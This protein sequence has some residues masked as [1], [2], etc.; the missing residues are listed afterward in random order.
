MEGQAIQ[1]RPQ[2][3]Q[4][5]IAVFDNYSEAQQAQKKLQEAEVSLRSIS[6]EGDINAYE[7]VAAMGTTV[8]KEAG[9]LLGAFF[10]GIVGVIFVSIVSTW[11]HG[12]VIN[13]TFNQT[14]VLALTVIG[15]FVG[16]I[17][18]N[19]YRSAKLPQQKQKGNPNVPRRYQIIAEGDSENLAKAGEILGYSAS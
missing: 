4:K 15:G 17:A 1:Q 7:E 2:M 8:G 9:I 10:G 14:S 12:E 6:I 5:E 19:R 16:A 3:Q 13:S 18:G 11:S